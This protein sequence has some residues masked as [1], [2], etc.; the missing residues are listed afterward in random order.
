MAAIT[1]NTIRQ[2]LTGNYRLIIAQF[3]A[4]TADDGDTWASGIKGIV[5]YWTS[6]QDDPTTQAS[7]GFAVENSSGTFTF[8]PGEDEKPFTLFVL[9]CG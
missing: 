9:H 5:D 8:H 2:T 3:T 6:E 7:T 4:G 1:P